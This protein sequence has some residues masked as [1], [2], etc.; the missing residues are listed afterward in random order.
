MPS[1]T[2][3]LRL[4]PRPTT[5]QMTG[6]E[7]RIADPLWLIGREWQIGGLT[8]QDAA[9]PVFAQIKPDRAPITRWA[10]GRDKSGDAQGTAYPAGTP[11]ELLVEREQA[12][13]R[14]HDRALGGHRFLRL[15]G[16][17]LADQHGQKFRDRY[18][19]D[20]SAAAE[21][22]LAARWS[23]LLV[24]RVEG[25]SRSVDG[26]K[27]RE[28][29]GPPGGVALPGDLALALGGDA[30]AVTRAAEHFARWW[31]DRHGGA[32]GAWNPRTLSQ[33]FRL[34]ASTTDGPIDLTS[35]EH[36]GEPLDW[37]SFRT[38]A[39]SLAG[40]DAPSPE[41]EVTMRLTRLR[42]PSMPVQRWWEFEDPGLNLSVVEGA[43]AETGKHMLVDA[44]LVHGGDYWHA[45]L[46]TPVG[47][48]LRIRWVTVTDSFGDIHEIPSTI[49]YDRD[50]GEQRRWRLYHAETEVGEEALGG[51]VLLPT[52]ASMLESAELESVLFAPDEGAN[53]IW[54]I[55]EQVLGAFGRVTP[56][57]SEAGAAAPPPM[58]PTGGDMHYRLSSTVPENWRPLQPQLNHTLK[59]AAGRE[60]AGSLL[61][62]SE[63]FS[64]VA[65]EVPRIGRRA[66][67][68]ARRARHTDGSTAV[69]RGWRV[70]VGG[71]EVASGLRNDYLTT[72]EPPA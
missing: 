18:P 32:S 58:P 4:E 47:S 39:G 53:I 21:G 67:L 22:E 56:G 49:G 68:R 37:Y 19:L 46:Q 5:E 20:A 55:L 54:A 71:G 34:G 44:A 2:T 13:V 12:E 28:A 64:V 16:P 51:L 9:W 60:P 45:S 7:A 11:V 41:K 40:D 23:Q 24:G 66:A 17:A 72:E 65:V 63:E 29:L 8:G 38:S 27:L 42:L 30:E 15:L 25:K 43:I 69:W 59:L 26:Q 61:R 14:L 31:D 33:T 3:W 52:A 35:D 48:V 62:S 36:R 1:V 6:L 50:S 70:Q 10:R 57:T